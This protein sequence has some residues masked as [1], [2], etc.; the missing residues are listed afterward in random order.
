MF[1]GILFL[2]AYI[3]ALG[4]ITYLSIKLDDYIKRR[5]RRIKYEQ[6]IKPKVI[7]DNE[8]VKWTTK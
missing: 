5:A 2:C 7:I 4:L 1:Q 8:W 6:S 3:G